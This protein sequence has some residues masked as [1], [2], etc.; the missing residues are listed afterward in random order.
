M[1]T[2]PT[3]AAL[4]VSARGQILVERVPTPRPQAGEIL[5]S[6]LRVGIC[7][8]DLDL[9]RGTRPLGD[10]IL[11]HEGVAE[12]VAVGP[13]IAHFSVGQYVTFL[14]NNPDNPAD[15][16][17]VS[18]EGL[19]QQQLL[20]TQP[21][22]ERGMVVPFG[23]AIPLVCGPLLEPFATVLYVQRLLEQV[24]KPESMVIVGA[25]PIGLLNALYA[26]AQGCAHIFLVDTSQARLDWAVQRGIVAG[27]QVLL[28]SPQLVERLLERTS[29]QAVD[30]A[31]LCTPRSATLSVLR[32]ALR[33][34]RE[35]GGIN[36]TAGADSSEEFPDL[37][38]VDLNGIR[39][40]N[41]CGLGQ[42][43]KACVTREGKKLWLTGHS[44]ASAS[45]LQEAMQLLRKAPAPYASV[46]SH[47]VS[48]HAAP[49]IFERLLSADPE[50][51]AGAPGV[52]VIIDFT[53][54]AQEPEV[55]DPQRLFS[56]DAQA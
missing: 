26:R 50:N 21:A 56:R 51:I 37:P 29:G 13:G 47:V 5:V 2:V 42:E 28:N 52:K 31:Y 6:P 44:G 9:L 24:R 54:E 14:P 53:G 34:V 12:I 18:S 10:R 45:Y 19:F 33:F 55:F 22:L 15:T 39:Q 20:V 8:S 43:V 41:V 40:A 32:Q 35:D 30:A 23:T 38:G 25:G 4:V 46:I 16:L 1:D 49:R 3:H 48:Y 7:G 27:A 11:G 36:L 17:G